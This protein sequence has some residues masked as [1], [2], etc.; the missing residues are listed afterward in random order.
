M[1]APRLTMDRIPDGTVEVNSDTNVH[2]TDGHIGSLQG[3]VVDPGD[4]R[5]SSLLLEV[6][7]F[8]KKRQISLPAAFVSSIAIDGIELTLSRSQVEAR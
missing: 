6:G 2:A 1:S 7:H 5:I 3:F 4:G 8:S